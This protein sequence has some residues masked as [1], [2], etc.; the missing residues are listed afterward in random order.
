L[1]KFFQRL[2][3]VF[4]RSDF[5]AIG[6]THAS[7]IIHLIW[8]LLS[9]QYNVYL[10]AFSSSSSLLTAVMRPPQTFD[11]SNSIMTRFRASRQP[12]HHVFLC[13]LSDL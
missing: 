6:S 12:L 7:A 5:P 4:M 13:V 11:A 3:W 8:R 2:M 1:D 10:P 9:S